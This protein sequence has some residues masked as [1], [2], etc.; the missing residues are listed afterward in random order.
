MD[1]SSFAC[2]SE[3]LRTFKK[4]HDANGISSTIYAVCAAT[5]PVVVV[6]ER[7][8]GYPT[9]VIEE[10][11]VKLPALSVFA[12]SQLSFGCSYLSL[13][14]KATITTIFTVIPSAGCFNFMKLCDER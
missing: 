3:L 4:V 13:K 14:P 6:T 5:P 2:I 12:A 11:D 1:C 10:R 8:V 7:A 9:A